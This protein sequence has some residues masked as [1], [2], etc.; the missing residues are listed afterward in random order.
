MDRFAPTSVLPPP[1]FWC[2]QQKGR[3]LATFDGLLAATALH[4]GLTLVT[5]NVKDSSDLGVSIFN[6]WEGTAVAEHKYTTPQWPQAM[7]PQPEPAAEDR[8]LDPDND[9][10]R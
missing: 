2:S 3:P 1:T 7:E 10:D 9:L 5:R 6:P 8:D 4:H